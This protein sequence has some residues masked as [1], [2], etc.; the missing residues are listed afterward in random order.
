LIDRLVVYFALISS[1]DLDID[2]LLSLCQVCRYIQRRWARKH[3]HWAIFK[4]IQTDHCKT[5]SQCCDRA[6]NVLSSDD[7]GHQL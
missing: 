5:F 7:H 3:Q 1:F 2:E 6:K 4:I